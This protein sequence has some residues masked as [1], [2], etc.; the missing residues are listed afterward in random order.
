[1]KKTKSEHERLQTYGL[2]LCKMEFV[3]KMNIYN[4]IIHN[5]LVEI[6]L[7]MAI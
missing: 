6:D 1:M 3:N 5:V 4:A 2:K 7:T